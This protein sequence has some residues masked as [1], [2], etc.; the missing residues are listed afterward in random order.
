MKNKEKLKLKTNKNSDSR[1]RPYCKEGLGP[2]E[3]A[4]LFTPGVRDPGA[5]GLFTSHPEQLR[6]SLTGSAA[7]ELGVLNWVEQ[8]GEGI[9]WG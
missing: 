8:E 7:F 4:A 1:L 9:L 6:G 3:S 5:V 2:R